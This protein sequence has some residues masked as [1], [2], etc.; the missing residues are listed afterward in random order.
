MINSKSILLFTTENRQWGGSELL[1]SQTAQNLSKSYLTYVCV[2][3]DLKLPD[4]LQ[5]DPNIILK[6]VQPPKL[7]KS[8]L[9]LNRFLPYA[10]R[11]KPKDIR[12]S[13]VQQLNPDLLVINQGFNFNGVQLMYF[14]Q[15]CGINYVTIS[16]AVN[17]YLWPNTKLRQQMQ[18]GFL[19]SL[20]NYFVSK[21]NETVTEAQLG[22][23]LVNSEVVRNPFNVPY[24]SEVIGY[25]D[26]QKFRQMACVGRYDFNAKGQDVLLRVLAQDKWKERNLIVNF[27]G[28]GQDDENLKDLVRLYDLKHVKV[29]KHTNTLDIWKDNE[30]LVLTSRYEGLPIVIV[31]AMLCKR[32]VVATNVSGNKEL[33]RDNE[34]GFIAAAPRPEYVDEALERAWQRKDEWEDIGKQAR[35]SVINEVPE[36]PAKEL[37][38]K[39][40]MLLD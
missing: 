7:N 3:T 38:K 23:K 30:G 15:T 10:W 31:E 34:T 6:L 39:I 20:K 24:N 33:L 27:Y 40:M 37:A 36:D 16:Q 18:K 26:T 14:A 22:V 35:L 32:F 2:Y 25:P 12:N 13:L 4:S 28:Q 5:N 11:V 9:L 1:W 29:H 17:E 21:D 8:Q 19:N